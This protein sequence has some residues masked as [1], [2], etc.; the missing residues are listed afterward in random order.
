MCFKCFNSHRVP[1]ANDGSCIRQ[2]SLHPSVLMH[3]N[4]SITRFN[5][6]APG[7]TLRDIKRSGESI[8]VSDHVIM[9]LP[10]AGSCIITPPRPLLT[11]PSHFISRN[12][13]P[14]CVFVHYSSQA[15]QNQSTPSSDGTH[16]NTSISAEPM[17]H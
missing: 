3:W 15:M 8:T 10:S 13:R 6:P 12:V 1:F 14:F 16:D 17:E 2:L 4:V 9:H 5:A 11:P 7:S